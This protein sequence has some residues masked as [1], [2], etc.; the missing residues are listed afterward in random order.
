M[1]G[2]TE[3]PIRRCD[4]SGPVYAQ[5][6]EGARVQRRLCSA[7]GADFMMNTQHLW[8]SCYKAA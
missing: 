4:P 8:L 3:G 6:L 7:W 2:E 1:G 5:E